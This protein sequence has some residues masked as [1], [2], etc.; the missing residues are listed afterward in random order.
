MSTRPCHS[1]NAGKHRAAAA[2]VPPSI[3]IAGARRILEIILIGVPA[4][5]R[6]R[7]MRA[8]LAQCRRGPVVLPVLHAGVSVPCLGEAA[9]AQRSPSA[10]TV[11]MQREVAVRLRFGGGLWG[12]AFPTG[13]APAALRDAGPGG[14]KN[15]AG[16][17][18]GTRLACNPLVVKRARPFL[19]VVVSHGRGETGAS[20]SGRGCTVA[21]CRYLHNAA[22]ARALTS[23][24][25]A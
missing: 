18:G 19:A 15:R 8:A 13:L 5:L 7:P 6:I 9:A 20:R 14:D 4:S 21:S 16:G 24:A 23:G 1:R 10:S 11:Q 2:N 17:G 3:A 12:A 22:S 25:P